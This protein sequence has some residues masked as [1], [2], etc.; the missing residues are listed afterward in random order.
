MDG[1]DVTQQKYKMW[2]VMTKTLEH[3]WLEERFHGLSHHVWVSPWSLWCITIWLL[4]WKWTL[5]S[6]K[7]DM[8]KGWRHTDDWIYLQ[9]VLRS[10]QFAYEFNGLC[11]GSVFSHLIDSLLKLTG[12]GKNKR[13]YLFHFDMQKAAHLGNIF[14]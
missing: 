14:M 6:A 3:G 8:L 9:S 2:L 11:L 4:W 1:R 10:S 12:I 13:M 7:A 5:K